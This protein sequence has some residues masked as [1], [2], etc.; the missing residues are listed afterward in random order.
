M[1]RLLLA[2]LSPRA[3]TRTTGVQTHAHPQLAR[4]TCTRT[5]AHNSSSSPPVA[6]HTHAHACVRARTHMQTHAHSGHTYEHT[7][8]H[9]HMRICASWRAR[10]HTHARTVVFGGRTEGQTAPGPR[11]PDPEVTRFTVASPATRGVLPTRTPLRP[12]RFRRRRARRPHRRRPAGG[13]AVIPP[14][15]SGGLRPST[16]LTKKRMPRSG[17]SVGARLCARVR[18]L[19]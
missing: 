10:T 18:S 1:Q 12:S 16:T 17:W 6:S 13:A 8:M 11:G 4:H 5:R 3:R 7:R 2:G 14:A 9:M 19:A 15:G